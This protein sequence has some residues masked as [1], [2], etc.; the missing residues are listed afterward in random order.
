LVF[1]T[2]P[3]QLILSWTVETPWL[4]VSDRRLSVKLV[5]TFVLDCNFQFA[6]FILISALTSSSHQIFG[7][8]ITLVP[9]V[10]HEYRLLTDQ[11][12]A[13]ALRGQAM[14]VFVHK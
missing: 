6:T 9:N 2:T 13:F 11:L 12:M 5:P 7:L 1:S 8:P 4:L 14:R 10:F 3:F